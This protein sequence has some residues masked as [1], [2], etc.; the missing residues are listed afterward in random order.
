MDRVWTEERQVLTVPEVAEFLGIGTTKAWELVWSGSVPSFQPGGRL[1]RV[2]RAEL[3]R[4]IE[5][6]ERETQE[7]ITLDIG[8]R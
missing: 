3:E 7:L 8:N 6:Q 4:Y 5:R 2:R 1:R